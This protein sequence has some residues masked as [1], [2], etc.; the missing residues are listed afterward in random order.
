MTK[1]FSVIV[2]VYQVEPFLR[3]C[4]DSILKQAYENFE[5]IMVD[6][7][8][9]DGSGEICEEYAKKDARC[10]VIHQQNRGLAGARNTGLREAKGSYIVFIDS[11]DYIEKEL[12]L[13]TADKLDCG[14]EICSYCARRVDVREN[15]LYEMRF[16]D[17]I[18][19]IAFTDENR[20]DL[21][22]NDFLQYKAGW[23]SWSQAYSVAFLR[24]NDLWF[25]ESVRYAEDL[26]FEVS[27]LQYA[28]KWIKIPDV[29]YNY[30][31]REQSLSV[32]SEEKRK[33]KLQGVISGI[34]RCLEKH[35]AGKKAESMKKRYLSSLMTY[36]EGRQGK[37]R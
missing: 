28:K 23:E 8:S 12:L 30:T 24:E 25:D 33:E 3:R 15:L 10:R 20:D 21:I 19:S 11:D 13:K 32:I 6:D 5:V 18:Q 31:W 27:V 2:P 37:I 9:T 1:L 26:V 4:L 36:F 7:G 14:Y 34:E 35:Y 22:C 17:M 16:D 29:L